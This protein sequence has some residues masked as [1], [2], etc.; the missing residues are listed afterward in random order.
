MGTCIEIWYNAPVSHIHV[1]F[2]IFTFVTS[3]STCIKSKY[4]LLLELKCILYL[5][6]YFYISHIFNISCKPDAVG[7]SKLISSA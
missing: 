2:Y 3:R 7:D 4:L 6:A 5:S 1:Y